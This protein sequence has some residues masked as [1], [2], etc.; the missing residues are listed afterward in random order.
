MR[1]DEA[2]GK[3]E[4]ELNEAFMAGET[5]VNVLHGIGS[6][7]LKQMTLEVVESYDYTRLAEVLYTNP[8][9]TV[10]DLDPPDPSA[11]RRYMKY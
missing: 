6:G 8:G 2:R 5:R 10:V 4:G 9:V 3:L 11:M 1:M 7:Q